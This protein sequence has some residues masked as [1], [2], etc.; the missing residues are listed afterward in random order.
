[1][2]WRW[3]A[4]NSPPRFMAGVVVKQKGRE[5][6]FDQSHVLRQLQILMDDIHLN[7]HAE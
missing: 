1:M 3:K 6:Y 4:G 2:K 5:L 7:I